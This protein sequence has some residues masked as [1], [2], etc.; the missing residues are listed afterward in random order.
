M[1][2]S[3]SELESPSSSSSSAG[4]GAL[5]VL[6]SKAGARP[7]APVDLAVMSLESVVSPSTWS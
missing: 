1:S 7:T 5:D 6:S 4:P 2:S 3:S